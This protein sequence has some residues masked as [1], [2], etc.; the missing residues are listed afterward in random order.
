MKIKITVLVITLASLISGCSPKLP[1][2][3]QP[4]RLNRIPINKTVP[5]ELKGLLNDAG[6]T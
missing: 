1:Q 5:S 2:P 6:R 4:G 3:K